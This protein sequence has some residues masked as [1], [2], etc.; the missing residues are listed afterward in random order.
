MVTLWANLK[1]INVHVKTD[2][3]TFW[4]TLGNKLG[5]ILR[6]HLVTLAI[7]QNIS[8]RNCPSRFLKNT[9]HHFPLFVYFRPFHIT[10]KV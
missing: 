7:G 9:G 2:V 8:L 1:N 10:I 5:Y 4:E 6:Q 3:A